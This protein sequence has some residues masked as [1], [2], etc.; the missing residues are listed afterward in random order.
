MADTK[1]SALTAA[2]T[3]LAGTE[4]LPIVQS[5]STKQVSVANLTDGRAVS[6]ASGT[7]T[8]DLVVDTSTLKVDSTNNRVGI[9]TA[10]PNRLLE[11]YTAGSPVLRWNHSSGTWDIRTNGSVGNAMQFDYNGTRYFTLTSSADFQINTGNLVLGTAGKGIDFSANTPAAGMTSQLLDD[12][13][14]GTWTPT[15]T[16]S[17][18]NPTVTYEL[19]TGRYTK[20]GRMVTCTCRL[21][22]SG[23]TGAGSGNLSISGL[24]FTPASGMTY[25]GSIANCIWWTN[26]PINCLTDSNAKILL[27]KRSA[28]NGTDSNMVTGDMANGNGYNYA[29]VTITYFV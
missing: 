21:S 8:G 27:Y 18:T 23:I 13:E 22:T 10:T 17:T 11:L 7:V 1:I 20:V 26:Y 24:P 5:G 4:V 3:P 2:T 16:G 12:Y 9:G 19:Q 25:S 15:Y 29:F 14:E 6:M 28:I